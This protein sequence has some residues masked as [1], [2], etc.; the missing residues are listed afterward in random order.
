MGNESYVKCAEDQIR[1]GECTSLKI[2]I[3]QDTTGHDVMLQQFPSDFILVTSSYDEMVQKIWGGS[4][5]VLSELR[6]GLI[7]LASH[8][9]AKDLGLVVGN[10]T[11]SKKPL[12]IVT[13]Q[14][15]RE[16]R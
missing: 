3:L 14:N 11:L 10:K 15:D 13:R 7:Y 16:F 8:A 4:C 2:C 9:K 12:A 5:N 6:S 1:Y